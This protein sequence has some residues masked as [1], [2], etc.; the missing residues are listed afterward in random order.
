VFPQFVG[1]VMN[2]IDFMAIAPFYISIFADE[3]V[4]L[5][6]LRVVRSLPGPAGVES[7]VRQLTHTIHPGLR[8]D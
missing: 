5:R 1:E 8:Y 2:W 3:F 7:R 6:F 4:D